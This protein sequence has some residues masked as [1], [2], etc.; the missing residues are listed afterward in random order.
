MSTKLKSQMGRSFSSIG[1]QQGSSKREA[2][3]FL[4]DPRLLE[5]VAAFSESGAAPNIIHLFPT[6]E[7]EKA[8]SPIHTCP[9]LNLLQYADMDTNFLPA[10]PERLRVNK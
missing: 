9:T 10:S 7:L 1:T 6:R 4:C 3:L 5:F 8:K 2:K